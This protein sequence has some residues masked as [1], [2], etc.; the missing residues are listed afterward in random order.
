MCTMIM[1]TISPPPPPLYQDMI[2]FHV[3]TLTIKRELPYKSQSLYGGHLFVAVH[4]VNRLMVIY[5]L[6][7]TVNRDIRPS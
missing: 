5:L 7:Y 1:F 6:Q 2:P 4:C 3:D